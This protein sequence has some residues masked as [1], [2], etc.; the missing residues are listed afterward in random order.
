MRMS[1]LPLYE[2]VRLDIEAKINNQVWKKGELIPT[3]FELEKIYRV[4]RITIRQA[5]KTL[6]EKQLIKRT[7]GLGT[8]VDQ[9]DK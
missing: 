8:V 9:T 3:E 6:E 5:L 2:Q 1:K 4:S 7:P